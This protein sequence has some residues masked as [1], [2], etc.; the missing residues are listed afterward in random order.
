MDKGKMLDD[1]NKKDG[2]EVPVKHLVLCKDDFVEW[3]LHHTNEDMEFRVY[4]SK[5]YTLVGIDRTP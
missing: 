3:I 4:T 2:A 1:I 5:Y